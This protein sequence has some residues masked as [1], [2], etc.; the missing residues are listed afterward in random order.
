MA[1]H[2]SD[3]LHSRLVAVLK[4]VLPLLALVI[5]STLFLIS[6]KI[7]PEDAIP[8]ADVDIE[9]RL[10]DPKMTD[11]GLAGMT[12]D[13]SAL[14]LTAAEAKP[15]AQG[16]G[17][18]Q[19]V[20]G[21]LKTPD[22]IASEVAAASVRIDIANHVLDLSG[23]A[24]FRTSNGYDISAEGLLIATNRTFVES[25]GAVSVAGPVGQLTADH[26]QML[27]TGDKTGPYVLVFNGQVRLLY[28]PQK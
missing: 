19:G 28:Q 22:G 6:R 18:L 24:E 9:D 2:F 27:S 26:M 5:L 25:K 10:R 16:G 14:T 13:G 17:R 21:S 3:S 7:S 8:Y 23:G 11:A 20:V 1:R 12:P 15:E 4:V